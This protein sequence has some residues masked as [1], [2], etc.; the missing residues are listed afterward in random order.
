VILRLGVQVVSERDLIPLFAGSFVVYV[1]AVLVANWLSRNFKQKE[2]LK[3]ALRGCP[4]WMRMTVNVLGGYAVLS[5]IAVVVAGHGEPSAK[6]QAAMFSAYGMAF[7]WTSFAVLFSAM[8]VK[9][10]DAGRCCLNG[11]SVSPLAK[12]CEQCGAPVTTGRAKS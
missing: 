4:K 11:H 9:D 2:W 8:H 12:Y 5:F 1:P 10:H 6:G 3:A 7:D